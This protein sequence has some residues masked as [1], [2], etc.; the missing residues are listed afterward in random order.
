MSA[1][2]HGDAKE[3]SEMRRLTD[4]MQGQL[5]G[6]ARREYSAGRMGH[7]DDGDLAYALATDARHGVIVMR[8]GKPVEW[9]GLGIEDTEKLR[10]ELTERLREL[11]GITV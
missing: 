9:I 2:H 8:F 4:R 6:T 11:R 3:L 1:P 7:E 10:D 5:D